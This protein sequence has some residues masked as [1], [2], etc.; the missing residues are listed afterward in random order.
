VMLITDGGV[1]IRTRVSEIS[2][3]GRNTQG[4]RL[5]SLSKDEKLVSVSRVD[6]SEASTDDQQGN[7][8]NQGQEKSEQVSDKTIH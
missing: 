4:V 5:I 7:A 1:L 6:E 3:Q 2:T 8:E